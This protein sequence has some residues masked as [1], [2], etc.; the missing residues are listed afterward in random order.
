MPG[1]VSIEFDDAAFI[2]A[3]QKTPV[4]LQKA[5][6]IQLGA[7]GRNF[8]RRMEKRMSG[9][10]SGEFRT[11]TSTDK[12]ARRTG[13]LIG[14]MRTSVRGTRLNELRLR[15]TI[16]DALANYAGIQEFGGVIRAKKKYLTIPAPAN[17]TTAG[18]ARFPSARSTPGLFFYKTKKGTPSLARVDSAGKV[19]V[20]WFLKKSVKI[21]ARLGFRSTWASREMDNVRADLINKG[22][23]A[24]LKKA[25]LA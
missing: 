6:R 21:P 8:E 11:N 4:V 24:A 7:I 10:L 16:G 9:S 12:L 25:G 3:A 5:M 13:A 18:V 2:R 17:M 20:M 1:K 22:V 14:S 19:E 23:V 15:T